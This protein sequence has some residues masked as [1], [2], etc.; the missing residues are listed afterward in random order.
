MIYSKS[1]EEHMKH[2]RIVLEK[3]RKA[4]LV[5]K[6]KKCK[7]GNRKIEFL[8]HEIGI[9][10]IKPGEHKIKKVR[11]MERPR[12]VKEIRSYVML[13]SYYRKFIK[14]FSKITKP[15]TE[16]TKKNV[17]FEWGEKQEKAFDELKKKLISYPILRHPDMEKEFIL[18]TDA[19]GEGIGAVL[20]QKD[21][22]KKE[23]VVAYASRS[24]RG[25]EGNYP[26]TELECLAVVWGIQHFH[27][28]LIG[29]RFTVYTDHSALKGLMNAKIPKGRR[30]RWLTELQQYDFEIKH[31]SGKEN[32]NADALSRLTN[33]EKDVKILDHKEDKSERTNMKRQYVKIENIWH[34][35]N[36][37]KGKEWEEIKKFTDKEAILLKLEKNTEQRLL[38]KLK[39]KVKPKVVIIDG[40]DG[41][42]KS[43]IVENIIKEFQKEGKSVRFNTFKRRRSDKEK[44][45]EPS[46]KYEWLFRKEVVEQINKRI[47]EYKNEEIIMLDKSPY[48]E[49]FY[50]KTKSFD[51]GLITPDGNHRMENEIFKYK[52]IIDNAIVIFLE[53]KECWN[54]YIGRETKK[55]NEGNKPSYNTLNQEEYMDMVKMFRDHQNI[56]E[57]E[58][59][60]RIEIF[61]DEDSWKRVYEQV[62]KFLKD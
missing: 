46:V 19:S 17:K 44:F 22:E 51:R 40:V 53:N 26:I 56:Y 2:I 10:G 52:E 48:C 15:L 36:R 55:N 43:T 24:L 59:Y 16:L 27:K 4:N 42:G 41:V 3:L 54:N 32:K 12:N 20:A 61:N 6:L 37:A 58:K 60:K 14:N 62:I 29:R 9:E 18:M 13:C 28:F 33:N 5:C 8:G 47:S 30:A 7:F 25:A 21:D 23:Y 31:R 1:F 39:L 35:W 38:E 50:Q 57:T 49:Y 34:E 11:D 45:K